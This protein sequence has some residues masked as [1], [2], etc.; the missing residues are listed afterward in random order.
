MKG[1]RC[2]SALCGAFLLHDLFLQGLQFA[3]NAF[4]IGI[5]KLV[6]RLPVRNVF[7]KVVHS[8]NCIANVDA[9]DLIFIKGGGEFSFLVMALLPFASVS[10]CHRH[11]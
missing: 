1:C 4:E 7:T 3:D 11:D 6:A 9:Q 8:Q 5:G 2:R 10:F